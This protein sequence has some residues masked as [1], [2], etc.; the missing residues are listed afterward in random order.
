[1]TLAMRWRTLRARWR[2][3]SVKWL[4]SCIYPVVSETI[5]WCKEMGVFAAFLCH[6]QP[7]QNSKIF[8]VI[9][10][11]SLEGVVNIILYILLLYPA[12]GTLYLNLPFHFRPATVG[13][14]WSI[15]WSVSCN[16]H[17]FFRTLSEEV[18]Y[19]RASNELFL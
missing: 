8:L 18:L 4:R 14:H 6:H 19:K 17:P 16:C 1:M 5:L 10:P 11:F 15:I 13:S 3:H 12:Y 7:G 9:K 2:T